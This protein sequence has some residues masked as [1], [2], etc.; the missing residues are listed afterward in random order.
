[1]AKFYGTKLSDNMMRRK[2]GALICLNAVIGRTGYQ[3][4]KGCELPEEE[5]G[6]QGI[7]FASDED[8]KVLRTPEEVFKSS[9]LRSF[10]G[11]PFTY[12]HP[13]QLVNVDTIDEVQ[14]GHIQNVRK[15][16]DPLENGDWPLLAD[17]IVTDKEAIYA[18]EVLGIRELSCG[19]NYHILKDSNNLLQVSIIGNHVALVEDG[20]AGSQAKIK[21]SATRINMSKV[22][23]SFL[24]ALG[25]HSL[26]KTATPDEFAV[27]FDAA[28]QD[29]AAKDAD[30]KH[31]EGCECK[32]CKPT[33]K[34]AMHGEGCECKK[35]KPASEDAKPE[36]SKAEDANEELVGKLAGEDAKPEGEDSEHEPEGEDEDEPESEDDEPEDGEG[37]EGEDESVQSEAAP[38]IEASGRGKTLV[39]SATDAAYRKGRLDVLKALKPVIAKSGNKS[40]IAAMD[41]AMKQLTSKPTSK[42]GYGKFQAGARRRSATANDSVN[43]AEKRMAE[44]NAEYKKL[45]GVNNV[46]K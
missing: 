25:L 27:A 46:K 30:I 31:G 36:D 12:H 5:L 4:Y 10:E 38:E 35:C 6:D 23:S 16:E 24:R 18:I 29:S 20:R 32:T 43:T 28:I 44:I 26:A 2:D 21:D 15:G 14:C 41:S 8:V 39:P 13:D 9:A 1:M 33:A 22:T 19:Y 45:R 3:T 37:A 7:V 11:V 34:D 42:G 17:I 40:L